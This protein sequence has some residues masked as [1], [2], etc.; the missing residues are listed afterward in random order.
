MIVDNKIVE[1]GFNNLFESLLLLFLSSL[2]AFAI[3]VSEYYF[4]FVLFVLLVFVLFYLSFKRLTFF[5]NKII[6]NYLFHKI[7]FK[8]SD[9]E[10]ISIVY[11]IKNPASLALKKVKSNGYLRF[12]F[13]NNKNLIVILNIM[14][15]KKI[16]VIDKSSYLFKKNIY[17]KNNEYVCL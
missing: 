16:D 8:Y 2:I 6:V 14:I 4:C 11:Q 3:Y 17:F 12:A 1:S 13:G 15:I 10:S 5:D 9:F 7:E